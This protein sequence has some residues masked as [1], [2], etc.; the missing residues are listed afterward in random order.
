MSVMT[1]IIGCKAVTSA[2]RSAKVSSGNLGSESFLTGTLF[3]SLVSSVLS[4]D[5]AVGVSN[6]LIHGVNSTASAAERI[7]LT[8]TVVNF[9]DLFGVVLSTLRE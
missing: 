2:L 3:V 7:G 6:E 8:V 1:F 5:I 4:G 9:A